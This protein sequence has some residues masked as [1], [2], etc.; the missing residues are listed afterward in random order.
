MTLDCFPSLA[1]VSNVSFFNID[2][3]TMS[4]LSANLSLPM[5]VGTNL[6]S[7]HLDMH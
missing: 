4:S 1:S 5:I 7:T 2:K 3:R 6:L